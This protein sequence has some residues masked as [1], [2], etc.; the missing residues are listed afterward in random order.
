MA[1]D[2]GEGRLPM[3]REAEDWNQEKP[4]RLILGLDQES[5]QKLW[6]FRNFAI[7]MGKA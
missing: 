7:R 2:G 4:P 1:V 3:V 5:T 6:G